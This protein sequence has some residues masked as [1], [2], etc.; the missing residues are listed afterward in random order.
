MLNKI[1]RKI[2]FLLFNNVIINQ[3]LILIGKDNLIKKKSLYWSKKN[4]HSIHA[5]NYSDDKTVAENVGYSNYP[6]IQDS[7]LKQKNRL[8]AY[9]QKNLKA[10][11][12]VL[13]IG[14]GTGLFMEVFLPD[15]KINGIDLHTKFLE[16]TQQ[17]FP[18]AVLFCGDYLT[19]D[20]KKK[21]KLIYLFG[22]L[23]YFEPN[24]IDLFF[25]RSFDLLEEDGIL[26]F[27]Y[28]HAV[29]YLDLFYPDLTYI[30]YAPSVINK[31]VSKY[32]DIEI[33]EHAFDGRKFEDYDRKPYYFPDG[34]NTRT[35]TNLN[36]Y[37]MIARKKKI[38]A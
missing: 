15:V 32:F 21:F 33:H 17:R 24:K 10:G 2:D 19:L 16:I 11:D 34:T 31:H 35:D 7:L 26:Y 28:Q 3:F 6:E 30:K 8:A 14:C 13:D 18:N 9:S 38:M 1:L 37:L 23:M 29:R 12:E 4:F 5:L 25:K 22:V 20:F 36:N 27:Q